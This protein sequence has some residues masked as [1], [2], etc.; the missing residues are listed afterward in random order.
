MDE[1]GFELFP[2][3]G[4]SYGAWDE[5]VTPDTYAFE[6]PSGDVLTE[7]TSA[8]ADDGWFSWLNKANFD[9]A[10]GLIET[11]IKANAAYQAAGRPAPRVSSSTSVVNKNGTLTVANP[12]GGTAAVRMTPGTPYLASDNAVVTNNGNGTYSVIETNGASRTVPYPVSTS[13]GVAASLGVSQNTL[14]LGGAALLG[15]YL[16]TRS[17]GR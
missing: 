17:K 2:D 5:A 11:A 7:S 15:L 9:K 4:E 8:V 12:A 3:S 1:L 13:S 16:L 14:L 6:L 10:R